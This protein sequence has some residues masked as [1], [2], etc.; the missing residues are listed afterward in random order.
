MNVNNLIKCF[1][2]GYFNKY[3]RTVEAKME[4]FVNVNMK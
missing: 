3:Y 4:F 2:G 1:K